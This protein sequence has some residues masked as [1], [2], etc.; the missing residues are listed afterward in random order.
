MWRRIAADNVR[1]LTRCRL[2][3]SH[4]PRTGTSQSSLRDLSNRLDAMPTRRHRPSI[5]SHKGRCGSPRRRP[6]AATPSLARSPYMHGA[7]RVLRRFWNWLGNSWTPVDVLW[8]DFQNQSS[9]F[10]YS[11][12]STIKLFWG[13]SKSA[14]TSFPV[15]NH[16][17]W[18][19]SYDSQ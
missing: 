13:S 19:L 18:L 1:Q 4:Y 16:K 8:C 5:L 17:R 6:D 10:N 9:K 14:S 3:T 15:D 2:T 7:S 11:R 12:F